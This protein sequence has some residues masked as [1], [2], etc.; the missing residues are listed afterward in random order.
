MPP[1]DKRDASAQAAYLSGLIKSI[2]GLHLSEVVVR[3]LR[4][5]IA[6]AGPENIEDLVSAILLEC[7]EIHQA[8]AALTEPDVLRAADR[9]RQRLVRANR[10][11]ILT[12]KPETTPSPDLPPE[13]EVMLVLREFQ[14]VLERSSPEEAFIFQR[15]YL[16]GQK[17]I[18]ALAEELHVSPQTIYRWLSRIR[19][20]F[21]SRRN[22]LEPPHWAN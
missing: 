21:L 20:D 1:A 19:H 16:D 15:Y 6:S 22:D 10:R 14:A 17:D 2:F 9:L 8:G 7:W 12:E 11:T 13:E 18:K 5:Y 4:R 3:G